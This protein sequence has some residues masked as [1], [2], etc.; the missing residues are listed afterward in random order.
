MRWTGLRNI[1]HVTCQNDECVNQLYWHTGGKY[2]EHLG[3]RQVKMNGNNE[4]V[5]YSK[6]NDAFLDTLSCDSKKTYVCEFS[7]TKIPSSCEEDIDYKGNDVGNKRG[8]PDVD[9][10][11][12]YCNAIPEAK[13]FGYRP[14]DDPPSFCQCKR[15]DAG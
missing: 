10:C 8:L 7:C 6:V 12:T 3:V 15:S 5:R 9:A 2:K 4:C 1:D 11:R 13:F 14:Q